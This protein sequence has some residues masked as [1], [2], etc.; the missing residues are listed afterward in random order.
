MCKHR[1]DQ[2]LIVLNLYSVSINK[3]LVLKFMT[4]KVPQNLK[5]MQKN[6]NTV[7]STTFQVREF[8][9]NRMFGQIK[10]SNE[11]RIFENKLI[12]KKIRNN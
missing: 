4:V 12:T 2:H 11:Y 7:T 9:S 5:S 3:I 8:K 1:V 10:H 6:V